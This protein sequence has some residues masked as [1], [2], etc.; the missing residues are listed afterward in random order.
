MGILD[1]TLRQ[2]RS[3]LLWFALPPSS[4]VSQRP[5]LMLRLRL[6]PGTATTATLTPTLV[7]TT[8]MPDTPTPIMASTTARGLLRLSQRLM[9]MPTTMVP[10]DWDTTVWATEPT[11]TDT[12][13]PIMVMPTM[14]RGPLMPSPPLLPSPLP[15]L[16]PTMA[17]TVMA[18]GPTMGTDW[19]TDTDWATEATS[20]D[21]FSASEVQSR[22]SK[23]TSLLVI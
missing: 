6:T 7:S 17:T 14:E 13:T 2:Q 20:G 11:A 18:P 8:D 19:D 22:S 5:R 21:K 12:L 3:S 10:T 9:L 4:P 15:M 1:S 23:R 16:M